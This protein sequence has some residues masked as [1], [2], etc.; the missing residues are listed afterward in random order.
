MLF[1]MI[2]IIWLAG[3]S[4]NTQSKTVGDLLQNKEEIKLV[5]YNNEVFLNNDKEIQ[6]F[7]DLIDDVQVKEI[8]HK[9]FKKI[10]QSQE[11]FREKLESLAL[12]VFDKE[13]NEEPP[14]IV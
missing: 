12:F 9:E 8:S 13:N 10:F 6:N 2:F 5:N 14:T 1:I 11:E 7:K 4:D 3:C